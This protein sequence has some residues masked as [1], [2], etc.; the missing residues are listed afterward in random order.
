MSFPSLHLV[1]PA[2][3][4]DA[5]RPPDHDFSTTEARMQ[6]VIELARRNVEA[7]T[8]GPF[9]AA[10][11]DLDQHRLIAPGVNLVTSQRCSVAHAEIVA[12]SLAQQQQ[13]HY[14]LGHQ[15]QPI[16]ELVS[17]TEPCAMCLGAI[18]WSGVRALVCGARGDD[19]CAI[20]MDE[21][22]KPSAW[23]AELEQRGIRV[24]RDVCRAVAVEVL[25]DYK[26]AGGTIYN[27]RQGV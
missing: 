18:P 26:R 12:I 9:A 14:D 27:A 2:W 8:G 16:C 10:V 15:G 6:F 1:L 25:Q 4:E 3:V 23:V 19:A 21:G 13:G 5:C 11:F 20:G 7:G 22:A 17:S 24:T